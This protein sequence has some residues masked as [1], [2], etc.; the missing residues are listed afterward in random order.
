MREEEVG[1]SSNMTQNQGKLFLMNVITSAP[2]L[3]NMRS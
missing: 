3:I 2:A 1:T